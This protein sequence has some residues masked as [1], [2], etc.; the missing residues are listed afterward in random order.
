MFGPEQKNNM[1]IPRLINCIKNGEPIKLNGK[2]GIRINPLFVND[3]AN[4]LNLVIR[5][6]KTGVYNM[7]GK[8]IIS[9][10]EL[11]ILIGK[12]LDKKPIFEYT[13]ESKSFIADI[14]KIDYKNYMNLKDAIDEVIYV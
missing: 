10:K 8:E 12:R 5:E 14:T 1:L 6:Q 7:A 13:D 4:I 3:A 11:C 2:N 9:L